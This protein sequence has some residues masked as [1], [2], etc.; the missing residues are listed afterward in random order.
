ML[1]NVRLRTTKKHSITTQMPQIYRRKSRHILATPFKKTRKTLSC[2]IK[3]LTEP[4]IQQSCPQNESLW[5]TMKSLYEA[6]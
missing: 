5:S 6:L 2:R 4:P 1:K 3:K